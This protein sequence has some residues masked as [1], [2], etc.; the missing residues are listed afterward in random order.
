MRCTR[1]DVGLHAHY[2]YSCNKLHMQDVEAWFVSLPMKGL[3]DVQESLLGGVDGAFVASKWT[4]EVCLCV[5][6]LSLHVK[7]LYFFAPFQVPH[8]DW[9]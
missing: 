8:R 5:P 9:S 1:L 7:S 3:E 6:S 2:L 4:V